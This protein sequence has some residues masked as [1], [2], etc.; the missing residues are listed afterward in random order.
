MRRAPAFWRANGPAA[1]V[2]APLGGIYGAVAARRLRREAP[3]A[4]LPTIV[5][6]G[7]TAGGDGK[8]PFVIALAGLLAQFGERPAL[9]TRGYGGRRRTGSFVVEPNETAETAGDEALLLAR[10]A[11]TIAGAD[12]VVSAD[13]ALGM[14]AT[15][16][17]LDDGFHSRRL[18]ADLAFLVIDSEYAAGNGHCLPAGPLRAP[19]LAQFDAA[20]AVVVIGDGAGGAVLAS[21]A[22]KPVFRAE[23]VARPSATL[24]GARVVAFAGIGRPEKFFRTA[25]DAGAQ[26]VARRVFPDH[27]RFSATDMAELAAVAR[28]H[29]ARLLTTEKDAVRLPAG[30]PAVETLPVRLIVA[31]QD[32]LAATLAQALEKARLSRA[33]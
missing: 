26:I 3:R 13:T 2:L 6:G 30:S 19:L 10:H 20:D 28:R 17:I 11:L 14:S 8:T 22:E 15:A 23:V 9:L 21:R 1:R 25:A 24:A 27:H 4:A 33:C 12:R 18:A 32:A 29:A 5:V 31:E 16:V 7:L